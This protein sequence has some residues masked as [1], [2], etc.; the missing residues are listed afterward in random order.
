MLL[1]A[2]A[3]VYPDRVPAGGYGSA[4]VVTFGGHDAIRNRRFVHY[5]TVG[6]GMG[7]R[8]GHAGASGHRVHMGNTMNL[9]IEAL[10]AALP[11]RFHTYKLLHDTR[12]AGRWNGGAG[13]HRVVEMLSD[14]IQA[15]VL[16]ER[17]RT[18]A[19]GVAGGLAG[20]LARFTLVA[21]DGTSRALPSKSGP[22]SMGRGDKLDIKTAGGGGWGLPE[23]ISAESKER[24]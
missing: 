6:G 15:S 3:K 2:L 21:W 10:E 19:S 4:C 11:V 23:T 14:D 24:R 13:I 17:T 16:G 18:P 8:L 12:G 22:H 5:E 9:P 7:A 20:G 1:G